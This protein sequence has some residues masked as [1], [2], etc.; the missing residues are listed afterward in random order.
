MLAN[1]L[2]PRQDIVDPEARIE[3]KPQSEAQWWRDGQ[4]DRMARGIVEG[5]NE[6][7]RLYEMGRV[8]QE[9]SAL[10]QCLTHERDIELRQVADAAMHELGRPATRSTGEVAALHQPD[11]IATRR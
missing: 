9:P 7:E 4:S 2:L 3:N 6:R 5:Q 8:A 1:V 11:A 10:D